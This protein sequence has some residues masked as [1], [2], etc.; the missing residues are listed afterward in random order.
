MLCFGELRVQHDEGLVSWRRAKATC[1][2]DIALDEAADVVPDILYDQPEYVAH[3][4]DNPHP[5]ASDRSACSH[6]VR[7]GGV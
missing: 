7:K 3:R 5:S 6:V 1:Q 2:H 4:V